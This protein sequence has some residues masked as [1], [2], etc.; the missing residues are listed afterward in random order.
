MNTRKKARKDE[1]TA[2][3]EPHHEPTFEQTKCE[4]S[5]FISS[6]DKPMDLTSM[7]GFKPRKN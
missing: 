1:R 4:R 6:A 7:T 3:A 5:R 2:Q